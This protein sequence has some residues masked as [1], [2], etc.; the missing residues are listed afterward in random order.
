MGLAKLLVNLPSTSVYGRAEYNPSTFS[1]LGAFFQ[2]IIEN[3]PDSRTG[4]VTYS[5]ADTV[6]SVF[7]VLFTQTPSFLDFQRMIYTISEVRLRTL[8]GIFW[9]IT[10]TAHQCY[11]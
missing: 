8:G 7:S 1:R 2:S 11:T 3:F 10:I 5:L 4:D 9:V 6:S